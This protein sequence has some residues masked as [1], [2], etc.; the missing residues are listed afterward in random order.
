M[1]LTSA[2]RLVPPRRLEHVSTNRYALVAAVAIATAVTSACSDTEA[3]PWPTAV[4]AE[5]AVAA[6]TSATVQPAASTWQNVTVKMPTDGNGGQFG[7]APYP[8]IALGQHQY[9]GRTK[10]CT[11]GPAV[12][13]GSR[14]GFLTA[15]HCNESPGENVFVF[16]QASDPL[17]VGSYP[18]TNPPGIGDITT[19]WPTVPPAVGVTRIAG[20]YPVA[21]VLTERAVKSLPTGTPV[22]INGT[23][24]GVH[25]GGLLSTG[26]DVRWAWTDTDDNGGDSGAAVFLVDA[27]NN[28]V[29]IGVFHGNT[30]TVA[31]ASYLDT[32]LRG[33]D[34]KVMLD[35]GSSIAPGSMGYSDRA[36]PAP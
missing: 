29:L 14:T 32:A 16:P 23:R 31:S 8:G 28:A 7:S 25:C 27:T 24:T 13:D 26:D 9:S 30:A 17:P 6:P 5:Q 3:K 20:R 34:A 10:D 18:R 33:L 12:T 22:C 35:P 21:G 11:A 36:A 4:A 1:T 2:F 15:A 19:I